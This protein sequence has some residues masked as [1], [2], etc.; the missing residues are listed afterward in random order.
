MKKEGRSY[1]PCP[2]S[3]VSTWRRLDHFPGP[4]QFGRLAT[5]LGNPSS[6]VAGPSY[7]QKLSIPNT[8]AETTIVMKTKASFVGLSSDSN[9]RKDTSVP[10]NAQRAKI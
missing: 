7:Q 1:E 6:A 9:P 10:T 2:L 4:G 3:P 5:G 8:M